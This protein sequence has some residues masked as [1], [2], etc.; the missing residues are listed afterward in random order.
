V[1]DLAQRFLFEAQHAGVGDSDA[2]VSPPLD[3][4]VRLF[5]QNLFANSPPNVYDLPHLLPTIVSQL[6]PPKQNHEQLTGIVVLVVEHL[7]LVQIHYLAER[8]KHFQR[9]QAKLAEDWVVV[10]QAQVRHVHL[11]FFRH[12]MVFAKLLTD[13][14]EAG[15][16]LLFYARVELLLHILDLKLLALKLLQR[17]VVVLPRHLVLVNRFA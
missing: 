12:S 7:T 17:L 10:L 14:E 3:N 11:D 15:L 8:E 13:L 6:Q 16:N 1:F 2:L 5:K 4:A 9:I